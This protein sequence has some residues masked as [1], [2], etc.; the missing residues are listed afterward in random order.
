MEIK[1]V[2]NGIFPVTRTAGGQQ[3]EHLP[4]TGYTFPGTLQ[5][6]GKLAGIPVLFIR[7]SGCNL[8]CTWTTPKGKVSICDTPYASHY[9][10]EVDIMDTG[11]V[12]D[13]VRANLGPIRHVI[14]SGGEPT[15]QPQPLVE[16]ARLLKKELSVHITLE[17]N[18]VLFIPGLPM[19]IDLFSISPKLKSSDPD[20]KKNR[21]L[22][23]P[24]EQNYIRDHE[25]F[26]RK[27]GIL[28]KYINAC[29]HKGS[30]YGDEPASK[31][32]R[33]S[34]KDFQLKFVITSESDIEEIRQDFLSHLSF[35][36]PTDVLLMPVGGTP[37]LL[38]ESTKMTARLAVQHGFRYTHRL[39]IDLFG[40]TAGT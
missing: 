4:D 21:L 2:K 5:G 11:E 9:P 14:I 10:G 16:L 34:N 27:P 25:K 19:H 23:S 18:G 30:Y 31:P 8:R 15:L 12:V 35:V 17:T 3:A 38:R 37:E 22:D 33:K 40:D 32:R 29:I 20:E 1:L 13:I 7:T 28:Q 24:V 36:E 39:Q 6:E 26:R